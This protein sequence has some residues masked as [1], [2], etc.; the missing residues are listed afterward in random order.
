LLVT[1]ASA[2]STYGVVG[3]KLAIRAARFVGVV[4][5]GFVFELAS[6]ITA[7]I[8]S[9][10]GCSSTVALFSDLDNS[11]STYTTGDGDNT[12][13]I[14]KTTGVDTVTTQG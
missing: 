6:G 2:S 4:A 10:S 8:V 9:T 12:L 13:V 7:G 11:V 5:D 1:R 3:R 14:H